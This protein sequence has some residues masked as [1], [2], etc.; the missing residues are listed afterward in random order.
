MTTVTDTWHCIGTLGE[1][2][3]ERNCRG[4]EIEGVNVGLFRVDGVVF[5]IDDICT[6]GQALLSEGEFN[7]H[8]IECPLH[9]G[10]FDVRSGKALTAPLSRDA[11]AHEARIEGDM[12]FVRLAE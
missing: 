2:F 6:H 4:V 3:G 7:G 12:L 8:E 10:L 1:V 5:A 9:A 11:R